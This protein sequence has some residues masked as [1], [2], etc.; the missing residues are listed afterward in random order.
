MQYDLKKIP[1]HKISTVQTKR[2]CC[3]VEIGYPYMSL[4]Q[5]ISCRVLRH[6]PTHQCCKHLTVG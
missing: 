5:L 3:G 1:S 2:L 6:I 4:R